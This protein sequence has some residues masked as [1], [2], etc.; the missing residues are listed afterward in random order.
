[1]AWLRNPDRILPGAYDDRIPNTLD[2]ILK[3]EQALDI[4]MPLVQVYAAWGDRPDQ[5][6]PRR[7]VQAIWDL[8][9][10]PVVTWEPWLTDFQ[11][12]LHPHIP[13]VEERDRGGMA[14]IARG[15]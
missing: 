8:G 2:G 5:R 11:N 15:R 14:A 12:L 1:M 7:I 9:S 6:F 3:L 4:T 13:L 10:V